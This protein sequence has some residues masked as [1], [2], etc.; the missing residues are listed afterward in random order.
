MLPTVQQLNHT[1]I[2]TH[3]PVPPPPPSRL[4]CTH[5]CCELCSAA[6]HPAL[7][8]VP[9]A[10]TAAATAARSVLAQH[11]GSDAPT[12]I[13][14]SAASTCAPMLPAL[15][16]ENRRIGGGRQWRKIPG[17]ESGVD[18]AIVNSRLARKVW[19]QISI[20]SSLI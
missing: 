17:C 19:A 2:H 20:Q 15:A 4:A 8:A 5:V 7:P 12:T 6:L 13:H 3:T 11:A 10:H 14:A 1:H 9:T 18:V 16:S